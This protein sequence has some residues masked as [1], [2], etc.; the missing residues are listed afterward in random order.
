V[1]NA[2]NAP[3]AGTVEHSNPWEKVVRAG[4][5]DRCATWP[6]RFFVPDALRD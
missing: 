3:P 4:H 6:D 1:I 2:G 5:R